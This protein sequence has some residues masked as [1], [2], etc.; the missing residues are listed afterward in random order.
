M[1]VREG[2][3]ITTHSSN[4][5]FQMQ[6]TFFLNSSSDFSSKA[7]SK[8]GFVGYNSLASFQD[9]IF[10]NFKVIGVDSFKINDFA[11]DAEG[12]FSHSGSALD[13]S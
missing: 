11:G 1:G 13:D 4:R 10:Y 5:G 9:R 12:F 3:I 6:E 8:R 7:G 2:S